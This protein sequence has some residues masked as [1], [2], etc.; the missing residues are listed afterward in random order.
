MERRTEYISDYIN[1]L[2]DINYS[3]TG[4]L[5]TA[6]SII[7]NYNSLSAKQRLDLTTKLKDVLETYNIPVLSLHQRIRIFTKTRLK[8]VT[9]LFHQAE[10]L[11]AKVI[12][13][14]MSTVGNQL[15]DK[16]YVDKLHELQEKYGVLYNFERYKAAV[17]FIQHEFFSQELQQKVTEG[18][19]RLLEDK[20]DISA[21]IAEFVVNYCQ[22][23]RPKS[24]I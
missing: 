6:I 19:K 11:G 20:I 13:L 17:D 5:Q 10:L 3:L 7:E 4:G 8:E 23:K 1:A 24:E 14:H 18:R 22:K 16:K 15:F 9:Q 2:K 21:W 12:V